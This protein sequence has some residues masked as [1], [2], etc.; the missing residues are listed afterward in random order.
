M[1]IVRAWIVTWTSLEYVIHFPTIFALYKFSIMFFKDQPH[2]YSWTEL[3]KLHL[4]VSVISI[5]KNMTETLVELKAGHVRIGCGLCFIAAIDP[6]YDM[7][8]INLDNM[9]ATKNKHH[10]STK[11][12]SNH[13]ENHGCLLPKASQTLAHP[14]SDR[15]NGSRLR[16]VAKNCPELVNG[17]SL[18]A[19]N[20]WWMYNLLLWQVCNGQY[21]QDN[22]VS[23]GLSQRKSSKGNGLDSFAPC[24]FNWDCLRKYACH[25]PGS[26]MFFL[27]ASR[28]INRSMS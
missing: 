5:S 20:E 19:S 11:C 16:S 14:E 28:C 1:T 26:G 17:H 23:S 8:H 9:F 25:P 10:T 12:D 22:H 3:G 2:R 4:L 27:V 24:Q 6:K 13:P 15:C 21:P 18:S 7:K